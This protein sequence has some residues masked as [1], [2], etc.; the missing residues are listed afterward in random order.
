[1][2][3]ATVAILALSSFV[4]LMLLAGKIVD[5]RKAET[6]RFARYIRLHYPK[7]DE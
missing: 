7:D 1:M 3:A 6:D 4:W 2:Y 5:S